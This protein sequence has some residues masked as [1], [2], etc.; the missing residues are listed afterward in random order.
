MLSVAVLVIQYIQSLLPITAA[1]ARI[2]IPLQ[3]VSEKR[4][5]TSATLMDL[6]NE[7]TTSKLSIFGQVTVWKPASPC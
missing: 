4:A 1:S 7:N 5:S 3:Q 6:K 2:H